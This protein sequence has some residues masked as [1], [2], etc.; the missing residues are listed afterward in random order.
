M[1]LSHSVSLSLPLMQSE[2]NTHIQIWFSL[3]KYDRDSVSY[4]DS[5]SLAQKAN[6]NN[7]HEIINLDV[8]RTSFPE[9]NKTLY[10]EYLFN[11]LITL[12]HIHPSIGYCQRM[13]YIASMLIEMTS[14]EETAFHIFNAILTCSSFGDLFVNG[15]AL[16]KKYFYVFERLLTVYLPEV[17]GVL[18][19]N[20]VNPSYYISPWFITLFTF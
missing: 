11:I 9:N 15:F 6:N 17:S 20:N 3:L 16:M 14:N 19:Q 5:L 12:N 8:T 10:K 18:K 1:L 13:S 2:F 4:K 7:I